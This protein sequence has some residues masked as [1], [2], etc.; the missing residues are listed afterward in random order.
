[1]PESNFKLLVITDQA[2]CVVCTVFNESDGLHG[3]LPP[4]LCFSIDE[5]CLKMIKPL[6]IADET[7]RR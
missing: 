3:A 4:P 1:M 5:L 2:F 7:V 6:V